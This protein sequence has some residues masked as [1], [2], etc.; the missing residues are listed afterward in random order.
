MDE[1]RCEIRLAEEAEGKPTRLI[2]TL[3]PYGTEARDRREL[4]EAGSLTWDPKG[5]VVNRMHQRASPIMRVIPVEVEGRLMIDAPI[6]DTAAGRDCASEVRSGLLASLSVEFRA[7][8]QNIVGG[9]RRISAAVLTG[10]AV[11]DAGAYE[12]ATVEARALAERRASDRHTQEFM[13]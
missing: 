9:L 8:H 4:F 2:G 1:I 6:P 11:C 10:A 12:A 5:I 3:M 13:L 7:V